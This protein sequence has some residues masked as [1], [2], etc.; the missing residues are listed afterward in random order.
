MTRLRVGLIVNPIAGI[1]G[2]AGHKGSDKDWQADLDAGFEPRSGERA[3]RFVDEV[4]D[5]VDWLTL[6]GDMGVPGLP[7]LDTPAKRIGHTGPQDTV[8]AARDLVDAGIDLLVFTGGDGTATDVAGAVGDDA[9]CLGLPAGV[10]I[11]SPVFAHDIPE[12]A[13][14]V[15][16]LLPGFET[17]ARDVT[18]LDEAAYRDGRLETHLTGSLHVPL[19]PMV[20][21]G[22]VATTQETPLDGLVEH[23]LQDWDRQAVHI[24]GAGSVCRALKQT[25]WGDPTLLGVDVVQGDRIAVADADGPTLE[26]VIDA[27]DGPVHI[28]VSL[29]GGQG[30]AIGR[31][32]QVITPPVL[33]QAGWD[34]FHVIAPPEKLLGLRGI[35]IDSGD[36]DLDATA[37]KYLRVIAGRNETRMVR[38]NPPPKTSS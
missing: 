12:A 6:P 29:I 31:G 38:V 26:S 34:H 24:I 19:S 5:A 11:T 8:Q 1:G 33:A 22:K 7:S 14:L 4:G 25:F 28:H 30:V 13:W 32:T 23:A 36:P 9:P 18:D 35:T 10:K 27:H 21:G 2:A 17:V 20:Q 37:P 16:H 3:Q 15:R